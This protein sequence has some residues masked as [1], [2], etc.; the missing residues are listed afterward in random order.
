M[1]KISGYFA[2]FR[3]FWPLFA[4]QFQCAA[5]NSLFHTEQGIAYPGTG[6][7]SPKQGIAC[8]NCSHDINPLKPRE[9]NAPGT[10]EAWS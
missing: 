2:P 4:L 1:L 10:P 5:I 7:F 3:R 9:G 6:N 8:R